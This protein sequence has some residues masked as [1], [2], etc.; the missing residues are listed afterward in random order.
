MQVVVKIRKGD[1][2]DFVR[3]ITQFFVSH[4]K[5]GGS[6]YSLTLKTYKNF[7]RD[8]GGSAAGV[9]LDGT[10]IELAL[11]SRLG[12]NDIIIA[13]SHEMIHVKQLAR[14]KLKYNGETPIWCGKEAGHYSY[15]DRPWEIQ[16]YSQMIDLIGALPRMK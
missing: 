15:E 3:A 8:T 10:N 1:K 5:L 6:R 9:N 12:P 4:L 16:A 2:Q 14:G 13:I 7:E 11:D